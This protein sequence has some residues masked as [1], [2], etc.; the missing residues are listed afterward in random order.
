MLF[1]SQGLCSARASRTK[2]AAPRRS[3]ALRRPPPQGRGSRRS[4]EAGSACSDTQVWLRFQKGLLNRNQASLCR[5]LS[6]SETLALGPGD[7]LGLDLLQWDVE[8][9]SDQLR[10]DGALSAVIYQKA[11]QVIGVSRCYR[12]LI[13][14]RLDGF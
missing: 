5:G 12:K 2:R 6:E 4:R 13:P 14:V 3:R 9:E 7:D 10:N 8:G 11:L 1:E